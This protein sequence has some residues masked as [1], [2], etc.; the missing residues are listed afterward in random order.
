MSGGGGSLQREVRRLR[1]DC[2]VANLIHPVSLMLNFG[3]FLAVVGALVTLPELWREPSLVAAA[4]AA[5]LTAA[6]VWLSWIRISGVWHC[7]AAR[8]RVVPY[9]QTRVGANDKPYTSGAFVHGFGVANKMA[10]LDAAASARGVTQPSDFGF[11]DE[12]RGWWDARDGLRTL[13]AIAGSVA[14]SDELGQDLAAL[15]SALEKAAE[16]E[17]QFALLVRLGPDAFISLWEIDT[18]KGSFW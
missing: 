11:S 16:K 10:A 9:F 17:I 7:I 15:R 8:P 6:A 4:S 2:L 3:M 13:D 12:P 1:G 14:D 18:R 5:I